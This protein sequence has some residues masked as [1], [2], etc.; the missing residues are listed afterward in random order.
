MTILLTGITTMTTIPD[1]ANYKIYSLSGVDL[2]G[3]ALAPVMTLT[4]PSFVMTVDF[5]LL[6]AAIDPC[7]RVPAMCT[8]AAAAR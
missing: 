4:P 3:G 2:G 6:E 1:A 5:T 8:A 7:E